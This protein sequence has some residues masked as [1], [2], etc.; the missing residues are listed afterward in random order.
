MEYFRLYRVS[1]KTNK[2]GNHRDYFGI[3]NFK[4]YGIETYN[5]YNNLNDYYAILTIYD[6][7]TGKRNIVN[8][9]YLK[10]LLL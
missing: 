7:A 1:K 9:D 8:G 3:D 10:K 4:K 6:N 2:K 5:R